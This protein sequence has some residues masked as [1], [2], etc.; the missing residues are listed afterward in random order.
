MTEVY[1]ACNRLLARGE[2]KPA[3]LMSWTASRMTMSVVG[4]LLRSQAAYNRSRI[5]LRSDAYRR[6]QIEA[7]CRFLLRLAD[8]QTLSFDFCKRLHNG[9][10]LSSNV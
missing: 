5:D 1:D 7:R 3:R 6:Q 10:G 8:C 2:T 9:S 4:T